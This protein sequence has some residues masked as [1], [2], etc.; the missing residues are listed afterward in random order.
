MSS[1]KTQD[2]D[3]STIYKCISLAFFS[4][5]YFYGV[6]EWPSRKPE[7][8]CRMVTL[9]HGVVATVVGAWLCGQPSFQRCNEQIGPYHTMLMTWSWGYFAFDFSWCLYYWPH[10]WLMLIHHVFSL[11]AITIYMGKP[12]SGCIYPCF[13]S[14][15]EVTSPLL[16]IRWFLR[17]HGYE[18]LQIDRCVR[19]IRDFVH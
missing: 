6:S 7:W 1:V 16:Q 15:M 3:S 10:D 5:L 13:L 8:S 9:V 14:F 18:K 12:N 2:Y 19:N 4:S 17:E 11:A